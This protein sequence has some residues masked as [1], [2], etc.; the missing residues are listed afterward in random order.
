MTVWIGYI[1]LKTLTK[2][3]VILNKLTLQN[4]HVIIFNIKKLCA[5]CGSQNKQPLFPYTT[6][7][8]WFV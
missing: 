8:D 6:L 5:L 1:W 7:I 2:R 3:R 4:L